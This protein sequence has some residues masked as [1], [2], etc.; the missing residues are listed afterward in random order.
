[1]HITITGHHINLTPALE[2]NVHERLSRVEKHFENIN[3]MH[4]VLS[5]DNHHTDCS[6][7][8]QKNHKAEATLRVPG[9]ELF[10]HAAADDMYASIALLTE[11]LDRQLK[12][13]I[14]RRLNH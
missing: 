9:A 10:A 11:K 5:L 6:H 14:E 1:M 8:G 13:H 4:V 7:K 3:S 2:A 12:R